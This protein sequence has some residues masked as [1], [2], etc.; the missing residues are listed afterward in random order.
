MG[1]SAD[2]T[3]PVTT[4]PVTGHPKDIPAD[5]DLSIDDLVDAISRPLVDPPPI[6]DKA[7]EDNT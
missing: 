7:L 2:E 3:W 1:M 5:D 6:R 4:S